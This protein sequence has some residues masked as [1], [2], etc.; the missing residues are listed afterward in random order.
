[1]FKNLL[2]N[3][4]DHYDDN[5]ERDQTFHVQ[6]YRGNLADYDKIIS[7]IV[8]MT[9]IIGTICTGNWSLDRLNCFIWFLLNF[10]MN[11]FPLNNKHG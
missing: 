2:K 1:M 7:A 9:Q 5:D 11:T 10:A 3:I 6:I 8:K 4:R